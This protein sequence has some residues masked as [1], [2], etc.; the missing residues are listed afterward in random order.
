MVTHGMRPPLILPNQLFADRYADPL[1]IIKTLK[2]DA[3]HQILDGARSPNG[4]ISAD[5][6]V[7]IKNSPATDGLS[8]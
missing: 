1:P 3:Y 4:E 5:E 8:F 2:R 7:A 6:Q